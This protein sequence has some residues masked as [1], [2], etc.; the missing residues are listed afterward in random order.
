MYITIFRA[1]NRLHS[2]ILR[3][4]VGTH[5]ALTLVAGLLIV[6]HVIGIPLMGSFLIWKVSI[7]YLHTIG[8]K[9]PIKKSH[10]NLGAFL[11]R[12]N[13]RAIRYTEI[14]GDEICERHDFRNK[15][16]L[17][18]HHPNSPDLTPR[19]RRKRLREKR[20]QGDVTA[21]Y[22]DAMSSIQITYRVCPSCTQ[23][24]QCI[25]VLVCVFPL[26]CPVFR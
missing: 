5:Y 4:Y 1:P 26:V 16:A 10:T 7:V 17:C 6:A 3:C 22:V 25:R 18:T 21:V 14:E 2:P 13:L 24:T 9:K 20:Q 8:I 23:C 19:Q 15:K 11:I 12:K